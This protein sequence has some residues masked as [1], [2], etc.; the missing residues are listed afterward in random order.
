VVSPEEHYY[1]EHRWWSQWACFDKKAAENKRQYH[2]LQLMI[3]VG[4]VTVPVLVGIPPTS[5]DATAQTI[6]YFATVVISLLVAISA[7]LENIYQFGDNWRSYRNAAEE[8]LQEKSI[9]DVRAGRYAGHGAPFTRFVERCEEIIAQQN[10][11]W[12]QSQERQQQQA[13]QQ[14]QEFMENYVEQDDNKENLQ[15]TTT[16]SALP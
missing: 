13:Q 3:G 5:L 11:R 4:S 8:L 7:A 2:R 15:Q 14:A 12:I 1:L 16:P 9:Y 10:G 6:L